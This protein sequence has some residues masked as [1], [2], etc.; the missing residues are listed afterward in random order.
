MTSGDHIKG[1]F[2]I[3]SDEYILYGT[4]YEKETSTENEIKTYNYF[5]VM[6]NRG[7]FANDGKYQIQTK[8]YIAGTSTYITYNL[9]VYALPTCDCGYIVN[10]KLPHS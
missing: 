4:E 8:V 7:F 9:Y 2:D 1:P 10:S 3:F 5:S 6:L